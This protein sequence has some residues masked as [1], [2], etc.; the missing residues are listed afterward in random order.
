VTAEPDTRPSSGATAP[1]PRG[2]VAVRAPPTWAA[3]WAALGRDRQRYAELG[4]A[5]YRHLGFWIGA[6]HR[7]GAWSRG[8]AP[9]MRWA[10][11]ALVWA[12][13]QP[14]RIL[15]HVELP[16]TARIGPGFCIVHPYSVLVG[17]EVEFGADCLVFHEVTVGLGMVPGF[18]VIG[19][20][21]HLYA[22]ARVLGGVAIG[23]GARV[24]A[25]CVV[26]GNVPPRSVVAPPPSR[27]IPQALLDR[28]RP[29][30]DR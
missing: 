14:W 12:A 8:L 28:N 23:E 5:W 25:N 26:L 4:A 9:P 13:R 3:T 10:V 2:G 15:L 22:G 1:E 18:P 7:F 17:G 21:V 11:R 27:P 16:D 19:D 6:T 24:G 20:G 30:G 29:G